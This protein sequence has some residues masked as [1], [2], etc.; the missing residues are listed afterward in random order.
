MKVKICPRCGS[1]DI[2]WIIPQNWSMWSCNNCSFTGPVVEVDKQTQEE[3]QEYWS[4]NKKKILAKTKENNEE[5]DL[6]DEEL[7]EMLDKLFDEK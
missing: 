4:K 7:D 5:D 1:S 2:K 6:S 3:I